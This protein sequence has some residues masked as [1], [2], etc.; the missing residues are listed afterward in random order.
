ME[1]YENSKPNYYAVIPAI[2]RYDND[3]M[4]KAKILYGEISALSGKY[5]YCFATNQYFANLYNI[6]D[7]QVRRLLN[8]L[9]SKGYIII[10]NES[11][12]RKIYTFEGAIELTFLLDK[13]VRP[14]TKMSAYPGQKCPP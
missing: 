3:V 12:L 1:D 13:N 5:G 2:V 8:S 14:R 9:S 10:D 6:S 11:E 7:R 4:D